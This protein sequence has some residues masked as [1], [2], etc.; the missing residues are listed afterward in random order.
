MNPSL[1]TKLEQLI[2]RYEELGALLSDNDTIVNQ[3][4]FRTYAKEYAEIE[5]VVLAYRQWQQQ[6]TELDEAR[7]MMQDKDSEISAMASEEAEELEDSLDGIDD[8]IQR[9]L[10]PNDPNDSHN[11]FLEIRAGT[12]LSLIHI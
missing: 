4:L 6:S 12:G 8:N 2:E 10:I 1:Q 7:Q 5:P 11:I 9:L 3:D